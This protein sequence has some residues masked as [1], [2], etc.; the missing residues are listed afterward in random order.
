[1]VTLP[2]IVIRKPM[3]NTLSDEVERVTVAAP[4]KPLPK[5]KPKP[6]PKLAESSDEEEHTEP[7]DV[8]DPMYVDNEPPEVKP[9]KSQKKVKNVVPVGRNGLKKKRVVKSKM[10]LDAKGY[11]GALHPPSGPIYSRR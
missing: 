11:M 7:E 10:S 9:K 2:L 8:E 6:K 5:S 4:T 3:L 1:M